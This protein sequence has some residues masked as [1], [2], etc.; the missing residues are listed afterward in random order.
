M[1]TSKPRKMNPSPPYAI[2]I[3]SCKRTYAHYGL[4]RSN[5]EYLRPAHPTVGTAMI[6]LTTTSGVSKVR[7]G[8]RQ[9][10]AT[11]HANIV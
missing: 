2:R 9:A 10:K 6:Q 5:A 1:K 7:I 3:A 8:K 4:Y 11:D